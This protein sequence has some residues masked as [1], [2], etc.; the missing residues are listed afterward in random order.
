MNSIPVAIATGAVT[1]SMA[2]ASSATGRPSCTASDGACTSHLVRFQ[3]QA[4]NDSTSPYAVPL[5]ALGGRTL[6]QYLADH[7]ELRLS[8]IR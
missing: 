5:E 3:P 7:N 8:R 1:V 4:D 6:A 2:M